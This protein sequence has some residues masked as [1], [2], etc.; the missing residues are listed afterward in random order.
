MIKAWIVGTDQIK[1]TL[2][3]A[4]NAVRQSLVKTMHGLADELAGLI[5]D[6][7]LSGQTVRAITGTGRRSTQ[8]K[9]V[10]ETADSI[11]A[12]VATGGPEASY[13]AALNRGVDP[14]EIV[15]KNK[16]ALAFNWPGHEHMVGKKGQQT[17]SAKWVL[18]SVH[19]PGLKGRHFMEL[20][21]AAFAPTIKAR[22]E[23][24]VRRALKT[25]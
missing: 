2:S 19:H 24:A 6:Q 23:E 11:T 8:S 14:Y 3:E 16:Q 7:Y 4:P 5:K 20:G 25:T 1:A 17:M 15:P 13:M 18:R 22:L 12:I 21:L 9:G 10:Q